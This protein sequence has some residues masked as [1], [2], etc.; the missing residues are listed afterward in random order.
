MPVLAK[1]LRR[2]GR[3]GVVACQLDNEIGM[4]DWVSNTPALTDH[5]LRDFNSWLDKTYDDGLGDRYA[6]AGKPAAERDKAIRSPE[7]GYSAALMHDLGAF[8]RGRF[9]R[10]VTALRE[11]AE[12]NGVRGVPFLINIHGTGGG[13]A[14]NFP[15]GISQLMETYSGKP[16]MISG[17]DFYLGDLSFRNVTDLYLVNAFMDAVHDGDQ[18]VTALEFDAGHADYGNTLNNQSGAEAAD[19]KTRLCLA[20]GAKMI[21]YY[22]FAGGFNPKLDE[23]AGDGNDRI[24][25]TG[26]RHGFAAPVD[27]EGRPGPSYPALKRTVHAVRGNADLLA[28]MKTQYDGLSLGFVPDHYLT[29]YHPDTDS[30]RAVLNDVQPVRG[31]GPGGALARAMLLSGFRYDSVNLQ[32]GGLDPARTPVLALAT[33]EYLDGAIQRRL[34][35][36]VEAGGKLLLSGLLPGKDLAGRPATELR[37]ALGLKP[38]KTLNDANRFFLSVTAHGWAAPRAEIRVGK[39]QLCTAS[40]GDVV[41]REVSTG[42]AAASTSAWARAGRWSSPTTTALTSTSGPRPCASWARCRGSPTTRGC[43]GC[44]SSPRRTRT[45]GGCCTPSTSPPVTPRTSPSRSAASRC[46]AANGCICR[47]AARR[48]CRWASQRAGCASRTPRRRSAPWRRG[49]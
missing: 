14:A 44:S 9:A 36:Y 38:G 21:N 12:D 20:Q 23:P 26:E 13:S 11:A 3:Q 6:F 10:Y 48:C 39:A 7:D 8:M 41:L 27:P 37:D 4:L 42:R 25:S 5:L 43:P 49:G 31:F 22:L 30:V 28:P 18:P 40:R 46:S 35:R 2:K 45:A 47:G 19:L 17:A 29:E 33:G 24:G 32:A 15:I 1:R 16:G 34:V